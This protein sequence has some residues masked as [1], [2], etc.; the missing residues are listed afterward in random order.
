MVTR[1]IIEH[2]QRRKATFDKQILAHSPREVVFKAGDLVQVYQRY[3]DFTFATE[4]KLLPKFSAPRRVVSRNKNSYHL[5]T[6]EGLPIS[7]KFSSR[8]L[9][10]F[11]P[12]QGTELNRTQAAIEEEWRRREEEDDKVQGTTRAE[13]DEREETVG[14]RTAPIPTTGEKSETEGRSQTPG[15]TWDDTSL[16]EVIANATRPLLICWGGTCDSGHQQETPQI[17]GNG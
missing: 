11:I 16:V 8:R 1:K 10:R 3:L 7:G 15:R 13:G 17:D 2:A 5:V 4:R 6:L 12:R 14:T 9:R